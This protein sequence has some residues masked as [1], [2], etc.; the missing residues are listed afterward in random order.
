[1]FM[2][3][4]RLVEKEYLDDEQWRIVVEVKALSDGETNRYELN[5]SAPSDVSDGDLV[6]ALWDATAPGPWEY[7]AA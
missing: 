3:E 7:V 2:Y 6:F 5:G 1:M 4:V